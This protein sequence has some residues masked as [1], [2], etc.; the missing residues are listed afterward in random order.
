MEVWQTVA[1]VFLVISISIL[2]DAY[3]D[4]VKAKRFQTKLEQAIK[5]KKQ[6][7]NNINESKEK[8]IYHKQAS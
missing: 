6:K 8:N 1:L 3:T 4:Y 2:Y 7:I 5:R